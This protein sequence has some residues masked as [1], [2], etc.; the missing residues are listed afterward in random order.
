M[1]LVTSLYMLIALA[2]FLV[3]FGVASIIYTVTK[4]K[5]DYEKQALF[6]KIAKMSEKISHMEDDERLAEKLTQKIWKVQEENFLN[7]NQNSLESVI[8]P[9]QRTLQNYRTDLSEQAEQLKKTNIQFSEKFSMFQQVTAKMHED[10]K[11]LVNALTMKSQA[12]GAWGESVLV[13]ILQKW[14]LR[15]NENYRLQISKIGADGNQTR[16][17]VIV[18]LPDKR[19]LVIDSKV[20]LNAWME[21]TATNDKHKKREALS[22]H[23]SSVRTRVT[24]L[25]SK[26]Y[27]DTMS[28][29]DM[30]LMFVP[31]EQ[32][33]LE[34]IKEDAELLSFAFEKK[35]FVLGH[36]NL[37]LAIHLVQDI[38]R[39]HKQ[40]QNVQEIS[41]RGRLLYEQFV[42]FTKDI[43]KAGDHLKKTEES[44]RN[45]ENRL[46][47][48][49]NRSLVSQAENLIELGVKSDQK[50]PSRYKDR[51]SDGIED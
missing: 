27:Q 36:T 5:L 49:G 10:S 43:E 33:F 2:S 46:S 31:I 34:A 16:P 42:R 15:E 4:K 21:F 45:A 9:M 32:A 6:V 50:I 28:S 44:F 35:V 1:S 29:P 3:G 39:Q 30:V 26:R 37:V 23:L 47:R 51:L 8:K 38:W 12:R 22:R 24:E 14:G 17:D 25:A 48:G 19:H 40:T 7:K 13:E 11:N 20:T 41:K 18:D